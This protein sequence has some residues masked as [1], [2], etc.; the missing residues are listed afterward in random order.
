METD[1]YKKEFHEY[2]QAQIVEIMKYKVQMEKKLGYGVS[3]NRAA[4]EWIQKY[5][6]KFKQE[7]R[8]K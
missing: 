3:R 6:K 4:F 7:W 5:S 1:K 2:M 8:T